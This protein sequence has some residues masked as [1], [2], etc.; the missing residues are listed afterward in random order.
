MCLEGGKVGHLG[1]QLL[2]D[3]DVFYSILPQHLLP[4]QPW[5]QGRRQ[6]GGLVQL[7]RRGLCRLSK[8]HHQATLFV[9]LR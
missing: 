5:G 7:H 2:L 6:A 1:A 4:P 9:C 3:N 8:G